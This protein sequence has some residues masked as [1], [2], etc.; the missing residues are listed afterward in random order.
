MLNIVKIEIQLS[1][2]RG[3]ETQNVKYKKLNQLYFNNNQVQWDYE[4]I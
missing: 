3:R 2:R 1:I 4:N